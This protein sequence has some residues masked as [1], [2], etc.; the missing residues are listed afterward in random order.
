MSP[1]EIRFLNEKGFSSRGWPRKHK[2]VVSDY[3]GV[4]RR[5]NTH[6]YEHR[7]VGL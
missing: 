6:S 1:A 3:A 4:P 5:R 7:A 2:S